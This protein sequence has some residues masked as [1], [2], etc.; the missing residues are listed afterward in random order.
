MQTEAHLGQEGDLKHQG[1]LT[2]HKIESYKPNA[3]TPLFGPSVGARWQVKIKIS[4]H[5]LDF[6]PKGSK[7]E[8]ATKWGA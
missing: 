3:K 2:C 5:M 4:A 1:G 8:V 7:T 6:R